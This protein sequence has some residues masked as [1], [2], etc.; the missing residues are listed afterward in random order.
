MGDNTQVLEEIRDELKRMNNILIVGLATLKIA[1]DPQ[2]IAQ[3]MEHLSY[4]DKDS[5]PF[6][7]GRKTESQYIG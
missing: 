5:T 7:M 4:I 2:R 3:R 1:D 6:M